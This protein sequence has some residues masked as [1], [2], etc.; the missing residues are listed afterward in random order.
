V[1]IWKVILAALVIFSAGAVTGRLSLKLESAKPR[2]TQKTSPPREH[3]DLVERMQRDLELTPDQRKRIEHILAESQDRVKKLCDSINPQVHD[4]YRKVRENI[5]A[6]LTPPQ[7]E[8]YDI[9]KHRTSKG[10]SSSER[11]GSRSETNSEAKT[12][13]SL[14]KENR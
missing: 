7:Q 11:K 6:E 9:F 3:G 1:K 4:E 13:K 12:T 10:R 2:A 8:K 5:R 14:P